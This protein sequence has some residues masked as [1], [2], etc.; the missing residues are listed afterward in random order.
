MRSRRF[1]H[2]T[3]GVII[4][5]QMIACGVMGNL[6]LQ[7]ATPTKV[8]FGIEQTPGAT[9]QN[10]TSVEHWTGTIQTTTTGDYGAAGACADEQWNS[11]L[12]LTVQDDG[13]VSGSGVAQLVAGAKCA[14]PGAA[15]LK[16][17]ATTATFDLTGRLD[18]GKFSLTIN[19]TSIDGSTPG[20]FNYALLLGGQLE[21]PLTGQGSAGGTIAVSKS[22][23]G[24]GATATTQNV[25]ALAC[26]DCQ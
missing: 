19:A 2:L 11:S 20:L 4:I 10:G 25:V 15:D 7:V 18:S 16:T 1:L 23:E 5:S 9:P 12:D 3:A 6:I 8:I 17:D 21:I 14:G 24:G 26:M 22:V 13:T